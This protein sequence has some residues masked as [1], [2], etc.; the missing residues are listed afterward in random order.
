MTTGLN[1]I[2]NLKLLNPGIQFEAEFSSIIKCVE[3]P[4]NLKYPKGFA[5]DP[6]TGLICT[7][8]SDTMG[9]CYIPVR[10]DGARW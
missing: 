9:T 5:Y 3:N 10:P 8:Q 2:E 7:T 6:E 4:K 1:F